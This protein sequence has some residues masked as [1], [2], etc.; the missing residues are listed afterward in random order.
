MKYRY[1]VIVAVFFPLTLQA[2]SMDIFPD[3]EPKSK[4]T[5]GQESVVALPPENSSGK[6]GVESV[7][8]PPSVLENILVKARIKKDRNRRTPPKLSGRI[9][10]ESRWEPT[11]ASQPD[12]GGLRRR[13][14]RDRPLPGGRLR[15]ARPRSG[16]P[17]VPAQGAQAVACSRA[18]SEGVELGQKLT[19]ERRH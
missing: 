16:D 12:P 13:G 5:Q 9:F 8:V 18:S 10:N 2:G 1:L 15:L 11:R 6:A 17:R 7:D 14:Q 19:H 3:K 4:D